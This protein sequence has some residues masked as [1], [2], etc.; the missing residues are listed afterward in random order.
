MLRLVVCCDDM[1]VVYSMVGGFLYAMVGG[2]VV[3]STMVGD[4]L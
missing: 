4:V 3:T 2:V 1:V